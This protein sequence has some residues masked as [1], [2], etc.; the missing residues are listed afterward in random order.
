[1]FDGFLRNLRK[2][3]RRAER[4]S[5]EHTVSFSELFPDEFMLRNTDFQSIDAMFAASSFT[6]ETAE[7]LNAIPEAALD[8]FIRANTRFDS[9]ED[10]KAAAA[11]EWGQRRLEN[12]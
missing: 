8:E 1:M 7:D 4:L 6:L 9:W 5:G 12:G 11:R 3:Q 10:M 2:L